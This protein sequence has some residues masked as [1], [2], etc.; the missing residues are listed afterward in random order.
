M[1]LK[2]AGQV[3]DGISVSATNAY[4]FAAEWASALQLLA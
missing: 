1:A 3:E 2:S 4:G